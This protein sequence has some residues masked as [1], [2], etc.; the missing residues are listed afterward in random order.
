VTAKRRVL[1]V[2]ELPDYAFGHPGFIWWGTTA[3]MVIEGAS[4]AALFVTYFF[5]RFK[6][7]QWPPSAPYPALTLGTVNLILMVASG[8]PNQLSKS[9]AE[10]LQLARARLWLLVCLG[11]GVAFSVVRWFEF[12]TLGTMWDTN[13]YG[14]IVWVTLGVHSSQVVTQVGETAVLAALMFTAHADPKRLVDVAENARYWYFVI[15][16]WVPIY[17][18]IYWGPRWL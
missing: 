15:L 5:Y 10:Q 7:E 2:S 6:A 8:I 4:F 3:F 14:S 11:F 12:W 17:L 16:T 18:L 13:A 9:A 1:D